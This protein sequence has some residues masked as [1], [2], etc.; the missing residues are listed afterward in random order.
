MYREHAILEVYWFKQE[1]LLLR[2]VPLLSLVLFSCD[3]S[4]GTLVV[5]SANS[6]SSAFSSI[7]GRVL[8]EISW[9]A[10]SDETDADSDNFWFW[11]LSYAHEATY[12]ESNQLPERSHSSRSPV[13]VSL[14]LASSPCLSSGCLSSSLPFFFSALRQHCLRRP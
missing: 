11:I 3:S 10:T 5:A 14:A 2:S 9:T 1:L 4:S 8:W 13:D 7:P 6:F 12:A